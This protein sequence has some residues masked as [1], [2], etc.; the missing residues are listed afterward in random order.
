MVTDTERS[1]CQDAVKIYLELYAAWPVEVPRGHG[2][3]TNSNRGPGIYLRSERTEKPQHKPGFWMDSA[4]SGAKVI[5]TNG[6]IGRYERGS[7]PYYWEQRRPLGVLEMGPDRPRPTCRTVQSIYH[8]EVCR[9]E[10]P[11]VGRSSA[12]EELFEFV[13]SMGCCSDRFCS[14][15]WSTAA[16]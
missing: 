15:P 14:S 9:G 13:G 2:K 6:A 8:P 4:L 1:D 11:E 5:A 16:P 3:T 12:E 7:W 10:G